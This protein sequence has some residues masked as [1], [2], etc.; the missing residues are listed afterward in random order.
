[1]SRRNWLAWSCLIVM[2]LLLLVGCGP[3]SIKETEPPQTSATEPPQT[4]ATQPLPAPTQTMPSPALVEARQIVL[5]WPEIIREKDSDFILLSLVMDADGKVTVTP[6]HPGSVTE[7]TPVEI[8][9]LYA[10]HNVVAAARLDIAGLDSWREEIR[11]PM[12][13]GRPVVFRWSI[14]AEESAVYRGVVW[15]HLEFVPKEGGTVERVTLLARPIEIECVSVMGLPGWAARGLGGF[16]VVVSTLLGYPFIQQ[17]AARIFKRRG[18]PPNHGEV[19][20][21][22]V[23]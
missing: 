19:N 17:F 13:P 7:G 16:G 8:P 23:S 21:P 12:L 18:P 15:L 22:F 1:M 3:P 10:T 9:N 11:E 20:T 2:L 6:E 5:E 4:A 14:R